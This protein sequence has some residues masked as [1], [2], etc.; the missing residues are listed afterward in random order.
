MS[1]LRW[2]IMTAIICLSS[3][4]Y[5]ALHADNR[6][7]SSSK[8]VY[9]TIGPEAPSIL[10]MW[11]DPSQIIPIRSGTLKEVSSEWHIT[12]LLISADRAVGEDIEVARA[13]G[14][15]TIKLA[16]HSSIQ[17]ILD[18]VRLLAVATGNITLASKWLARFE[19]TLAELKVVVKGTR[20]VRVVVLSPEGYTQGEGSLITE[21]IADVGGV[22]TAAEAHIPEAR[23]I[24]DEQIQT[25]M[26][27]VVLL[28]NWPVDTVQSFIHN[29][30]Y[31]NIPAWRSKRIY[32]VRAITGDPAMLMSRIDELFLLLYGTT[33]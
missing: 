14:I 22:N 31:S 5:I 6:S 11:L 19:N 10:G 26:P 2:L 1:R 30:L 28:I 33:I 17:N 3:T 16:R 8:P 20:K 12:A 24:S 18:N 32:S 9:V 21:L 15:S 13:A 4:N 27:D 29:P 25:F 23:Q 7:S